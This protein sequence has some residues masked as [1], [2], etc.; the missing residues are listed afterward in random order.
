[1]SSSEDCMREKI[2]EINN[3]LSKTTAKNH[4]EESVIRSFICPLLEA[5]G[6]NAATDLK[7]EVNDIDCVLY[8]KNRPYIGIEAKSFSYG[9]LDEGKSGV[10]FNRD[11]LLKNCREICAKWAVLSRYKETIIYEVE[12]GGK[13]ALFIRPSEYIDNL[14]D[15][16][17]LQKPSD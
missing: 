5:L 17:L 12:N 14:K 10:I 16:K 13:V 1:M 9:V 8:L 2:R 7:R 4:D 11:R 15:L 6:W 3:K